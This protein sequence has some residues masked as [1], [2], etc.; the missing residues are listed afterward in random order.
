MMGSNEGKNE[1]PIHEV[2]LNAFYMGKYPITQ[3]QYEAVMGNNPY[4]CRSAIR[5]YYMRDN[6][7]P[8]IG[9]R[10]MS[11]FPKLSPFLSVMVNV[12]Q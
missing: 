3:A 12:M 2:T 1:Q 7:N 9:F 5:Y 11:V 4:N 10:V 6:H 8:I